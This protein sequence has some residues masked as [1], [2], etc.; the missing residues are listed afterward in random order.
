MS[1]FVKITNDGTPSGSGGE[2]K[3]VPDGT[4]FGR[5]VQVIGLGVQSSPFPDAEDAYKIL[6]TFEVPSETSD[7][8]APLLVSKEVKF[9]QHVKSS[10]NLIGTALLGGTKEATDTMSK[11]IDLKEL[12]GEAA[13][14]TVGSTKNGGAKITAVSPVPKG[15]TVPDAL[16]KLVAVDPDDV[17]DEVLASL[18]QW[19]QTKIATRLDGSGAEPVG[20]GK[21]PVADF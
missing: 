12:L 1:L 2:R 15:V 4:H 7:S 10:L 9:S 8:G 21:D 16:N 11:G 6:L 14:L 18:P 17:S 19:I 13:V 3:R 5:L 20:D